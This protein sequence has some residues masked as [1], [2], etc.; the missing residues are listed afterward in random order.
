[1]LA[2]RQVYGSV[3]GHTVGRPCTT[4]VEPL[5]GDQI[6]TRPLETAPSISSQSSTG[7]SWT[8]AEREPL[9]LELL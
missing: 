3:M 7:T 6:T 4:A 2:F 5:P 8:T 9:S 1:M